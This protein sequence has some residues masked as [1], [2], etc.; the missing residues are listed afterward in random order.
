MSSLQ[1]LNREIIS[2][3]RCSR[4]VEYREK[5]AREKR[6][7]YMDWDYWGRPV[8]GIGD[9]SARVFILGLA[10][11]AHGANRTGRMFTGDGSGDWMWRA[12]HKSGFS[13]RSCSRDPNDDLTL[14]DV[15]ISAALRCAPPANKP[16]KEELSQCRSYL[17]SELE[18]MDRVQVVLALGKIAFDSYFAAARELGYTPPTPRPPFGHCAVY[19]LDWGITLVGSYHPSRQNTQTGKLTEEMFDRAFTTVRGLLR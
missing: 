12:L 19:Q 3:T 10:P 11:A 6:R 8:P 5:V 14:T 4:L 17:L 7:M 13:N 2:C 18:M 15:Y 16:L 9:P 1:E